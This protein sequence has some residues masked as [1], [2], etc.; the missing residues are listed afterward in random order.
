VS[1]FDSP[2]VV[3]N[4]SSRLSYNYDTLTL[5]VEMPSPPH[6]AVIKFI[7][8]GLENIDRFLQGHIDSKLLYSNLHTNLTI[9]AG[10]HRFTPDI[11]HVVTGRRNPP[12]KSIPIIGEVAKSQSEE[13][14]LERLRDVVQA[15]PDVLMLIMVVIGERTYS[16]P[17]RRSKAWRKLRPETSVRS[18]EAF[19]SECTEPQTPQVPTEI[20]VEGHPWCALSSVRFQV[21]VRS[22]V[23]IDVDTTEPSLTAHGVSLIQAYRSVH[24]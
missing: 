1:R 7:N 15:F 6:E 21:W 24:D 14:L 10:S 23:P 18:Y 12:I 2:R 13:D 5:V 19:L 20:V 3:A 8:A 9:G 16:A 17:R 22:N 11:A 4:G